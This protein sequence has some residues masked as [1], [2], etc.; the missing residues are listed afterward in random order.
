MKKF[1][2]LALVLLCTVS[3]SAQSMYNAV[4][5]VASARFVRGSYQM[6]T[7]GAGE[8]VVQFPSDG[9]PD[10]LSERYDENSPTKR[11]PATLQEINT[12]SA[13]EADQQ[14]DSVLQQ[15]LALSFIEFTQRQTLGRA[16][17]PAER[18][19]ARAQFRQIYRAF[20]LAMLA[21]P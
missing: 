10:P 7:P 19:T 11:R 4:V 16:P 6:V 12:P 2:T 13:A 5:D 9:L 14:A 15:T 1:T 3:A 21:R 8:I 17:T 20:L 18:T